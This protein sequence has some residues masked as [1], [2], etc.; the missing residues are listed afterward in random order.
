MC[1]RDELGNLRC[2]QKC[3]DSESLC[4]GVSGGGRGG[5]RAGLIVPWPTS[6]SYSHAEH[7][8]DYVRH[9]RRCAGDDSKFPLVWQDPTGSVVSGSDAAWYPWDVP[10]RQIEFVAPWAENV[11]VAVVDPSIGPAE[12]TERFQALVACLEAF[13]PVGTASFACCSREIN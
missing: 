10:G 12:A 1:E 2:S 8:I 4:Y 5:V 7:Y 11:G 9:V 6:S 13:D 3:A